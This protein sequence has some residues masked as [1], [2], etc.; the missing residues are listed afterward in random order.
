MAETKVTPNEYDTN[1]LGYAAVTA[2]QT[3]IS[4]LTD[5]TNFSVSVTVPT[6]GNKKVR[7]TVFSRWLS[8][9][10]K[11]VEMYI[12]ESSTILQISGLT[13][14][15]AASP[16]TD[17]LGHQFSYIGTPTAGAHTYK[18]TATPTN[19]AVDLKAGSNN[20]NYI[21]VEVI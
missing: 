19:T 8:G 4:S 12:K 3:G 13:L 6:L 14:G 11:G 5:L 20:P 17:I 10:S 2:D 1:V 18:F 21:L 16:G 15:G 7:I 9:S